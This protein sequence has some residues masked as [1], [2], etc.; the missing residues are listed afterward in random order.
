MPPARIG[1][2]VTAYF[3]GFAINGL[4]F[5]I[6]DRIGRKKTI[7]ICMIVNCIAQTV[8]IMVPT[9]LMRTLMFWV[10]GLTQLK[11][12]V[13]YVWLSESVG[14]PYKSTAFTMINIFDGMTMAIVCIYYMTV[15]RNWLW[16]CLFFTII[17]YIASFTILLCPESPRWHLVNGRTSEAIKALNHIA[18]MNG[19]F[20]E[21]Q[22]IP[23]GAIFVED[24]TNYD[25]T[26]DPKTF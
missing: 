3:F 10:L 12:G 7:L 2:M 16:L 4:F 18:E 15:S 24:P 8:I 11:V 6:P 17:S 23:D 14:F 26:V 19:R 22:R 25:V 21:D 13:S 9:F 1:L 5:T 20:K